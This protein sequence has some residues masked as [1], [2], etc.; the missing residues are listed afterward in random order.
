MEKTLIVSKH[1]IRNLLTLVTAIMFIAT[2][3]PLPL[4]ATAQQEEEPK[5]GG[6]L[7]VRTNEDPVLVNPPLA[8][9]TGSNRIIG[10]IFSQLVKY[11]ENNEWECDLAESWDVSDD[12]LTY[13]FKLR[14]DV[15]W[16]DGVPFTS[17]DVKFTYD[18]ITSE[19]L[20]YAGSFAIVDHIETPDDYTVVIHLKTVNAAFPDALV[21]CIQSS[22]IIPEHLY[23]GTDINE[24]PHNYDPIG[25]GAFKFVE[26]VKGSHVTLEANED[27][28]GEG[29]YLDKVIYKIIPDSSTALLAFE[30]G[31]FHY[32]TGAPA[33]ELPR[34]EAIDWV[35]VYQQPSTSIKYMGINLAHPDSPITDKTVR[36]ALYT[37]INRKSIVENIITYGVPATSSYTTAQPLYYDP[38]IADMYP[39]EGDIAKANQMLDEAGY[40]RDASGKRFSVILWVKIGIS[41]REDACMAI[42]QW[43]GE[44]GVETTIVSVEGG[45][46][47]QAFFYD[48]D[49]DTILRSHGVGPDPERLYARLHSSTIYPGGKNAWSFNNSRVDELFKLGQ[50]TP[51]PEERAVHYR[52]LQRIVMEELPFMPIWEPVSTHIWNKEFKGLPNLPQSLTYPLNRVWWT[53]GFSPGTLSD[54]KAAIDQAE[55]DGRTYDLEEAKTL[56]SQAEA[57]F[58]SGD[59]STAATLA[60]NVVSTAGAAE[61]YMQKYGTTIAVVV[62]ALIAAI[63]LVYKFVLK[64]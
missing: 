59:Y 24:N 44:L 21:G 16:H 49:F 17:K 45:T 27:Y 35:E 53:K 31:E 37:A 22:G 13:T 63:I 28:Y 26:W 50:L 56:Y 46:L 9:D 18:A 51:I 36:Q 40:P 19:S 7:I 4:R 55:S 62:I 29:P 41:E 1:K 30:A 48:R 34:L 2:V 8:G 64:K 20:V 11:D 47:K 60:G 5:Y 39:I 57:A 33:S 32:Y 38:D 52:E 43:W 25:T 14:K 15:K 42:K 12:G 58:E 54:A 23:A 10:Q 61:T 3:I 6:T